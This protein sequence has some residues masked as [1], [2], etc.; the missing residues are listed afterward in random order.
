MSKVEAEYILKPKFHY[1]FWIVFF[2]YQFISNAVQD[3]R[4]VF[5]FVSVLTYV[6]FFFTVLVFNF[7]ATVLFFEIL[8]YKKLSRIV[9]IL[10]FIV[11]ILTSS[12]LALLN[13]GVIQP[14]FLNNYNPINYTKYLS[15]WLFQFIYYFTMGAGYFFVKEFVK[16]K[17][18]STKLANEKTVIE[19]NLLRSQI[20]PHFLFNTLNVLY[21][22][23]MV[24]SE[25]LADKIQKLSEIMRYAYLPKWLKDG[26]HAPVTEEI[27]HIGNIIEIHEFRLSNNQIFQFDTQGTFTD[28]YLP[29]LILVTLVENILKHGHLTAEY[30]AFVALKHENDQFS[31]FS[32]NKIKTAKNHEEHSGVGIENIRLRLNRSFPDQFS[33]SSVEADGFYYNQ[34]TINL[35]KTK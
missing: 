20:N 8:K 2:L 26:S 23:S 19:S 24:Y 3:P 9:N 4:Y 16:E 31:F 22:K 32:K 21:A 13:R 27:K 14:I 7:Y 5:S 28:I 35:Q 30:P 12:A 11:L 17:I 10:I 29:P 34:L 1:I 18:T 33:F 25:E 15:F 6:S